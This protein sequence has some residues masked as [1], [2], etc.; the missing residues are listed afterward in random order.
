MKTPDQIAN[1]TIPPVPLDVFADIDEKVGHQDYELYT[2][3]AHDNDGCVN[4]VVIAE[5]TLGEGIYKY[6]RD[7]DGV[8]KWDLIAA[9]AHRSDA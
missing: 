5:Y 2:L 1:E 3:A 4:V 6:T 8:V 7:A 9:R